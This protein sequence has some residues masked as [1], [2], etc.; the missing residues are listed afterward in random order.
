MNSK[1][2]EKPF[3]SYDELIS[4]LRKDYNIIIDN[5]ELA[6]NLLSTI[7]FYDL[8]NGYKEYLK[9]V[10]STQESI[11]LETLLQFLIFDKNIQMVLLKYSIYVEN[12][13]KQS[14][15]TF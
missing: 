6:L 9:K 3:K 13:L 5:E 1:N 11:L 14:L 8:K 10:S 2:Y 12:F 7:S 15:L 4:K